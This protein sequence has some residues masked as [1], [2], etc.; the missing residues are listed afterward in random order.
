MKNFSNQLDFKKGSGLIP[1]VIQDSVTKQVLMLGFMNEE[2]LEKTMETKKVCFFSRSKDRLWMK[3]E[4]SGNELIVLDVKMD[5]DNDSLLILV[6][7]KGPTC[8]SGDVSCF[9]EAEKDG[10]A[11]LFQV[12]SGRKSALSSGS[13][14]T[15]LF[16]DGLE[17]ICGKVEEESEEVVRAARSETK[18][19]LTEEAVDLLYHLFVLLVQ[20]D[21]S[22]SSVLAEMKKRRMKGKA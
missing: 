18:I 7:P 5:C 9:G 22:W 11:D 16:Q 12:I 17:K 4:E 13:Y 3:G 1:A 10:C 8:H 6:R 21:I 2:S 15:S 20:R 14:T 19:R